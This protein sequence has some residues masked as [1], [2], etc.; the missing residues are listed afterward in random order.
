[1]KSQSVASASANRITHD[2]IA[3]QSHH[4]SVTSASANHQRTHTGEK[5]FCCSVCSIAF[6]TNGHLTVHMRTHTKDTPYKCTVCD[7]AFTTSGS[8][9]RHMRTHTGE[10]PFSCMWCTK[11]FAQSFNKTTHIKKCNID[12]QQHMSRA[13]EQIE[14][15]EQYSSRRGLLI[16]KP[17]EFVVK[18]EFVEWF[19]NWRICCTERKEVGV[20]WNKMKN[21]IVFLLDRVPT[22]CV[23]NK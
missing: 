11:T 21:E 13:S 4:P 12:M 10:K 17:Y 14:S 2:I 22:W 20:E 23:F 7:R 18:E 15:T 9:A 8:L 1:M 5:N 3:H 16:D 6:T 19:D